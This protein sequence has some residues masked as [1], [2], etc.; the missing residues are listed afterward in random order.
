[1]RRRT[2]G[3]AVLALVLA[4]ALPATAHGRGL[5]LGVMDFGIFEGAD[6]GAWYARTSDAGAS[7]VRLTVSWASLAPTRPANPRDPL[8]PRYDWGRTDAAVRGAVAHGLQPF[9][10]AQ[11]APAWAEGP[12]RP[13]DAP[14]GS[15]RPDPAAYADF[16]EALARRYDGTT[17][18]R[19]RLWQPWNE[20]NLPLY[21]T[22]QWAGTG[23][24]AKPA[25][26]GWYR[27]MLNAAYA[28]I[29]A[30][31]PDNLVVAAGTAP[32]GDAP[33]YDNRMTPVRFLRELLGSR[34]TPARLDAID[35][36]P[37]ATGSPA[38]HALL[39]EN[40]A[41][42][43]LHKLVAVLRAAR[44][45]HTVAPAGRKRVWV[46]EVSWDSDPPDPHGVPEARRAR[47]L[48]D[49]FHSL[50][51][52]GADTICWYLL[53]DDAPGPSYDATYQSG[54]FLRNGT[55]KLSVAAFRLP[56]VLRRSG[57]RLTA[58]GRAPARARVTIERRRGSSWTPIATLR[59]HGGVYQGRLAAPRGALLRARQGAVTGLARR[60][61][62]T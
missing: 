16:M 51:R 53:R 28:R 14:Q 11:Y 59:P 20:P 19:V 18:P 30:V 21:L 42:P 17:Q 45:R 46:T 26:P 23:P 50:W 13:A 47:W 24:K 9:V 7:M 36:H 34:A 2:L 6:S 41:I 60:S 49:A 39:P 35:H 25:S 57:G 58:W 44:K 12:G 10:T 54:L 52:Q 40:V 31:H 33:Q 32:Y 38:A 27:R 8:D 1:M 48:Q 5:T 62:G 61:P 3:G 56:L 29:K 4:V 55:P 15:W 37:Y 22:P 43:D